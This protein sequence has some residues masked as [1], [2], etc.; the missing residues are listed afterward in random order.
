MRRSE[1]STIIAEL[2]DRA[3]K[4]ESSTAV[5][6]TGPRATIANAVE[7]VASAID[8]TM[9]VSKYLGETEENLGT[10]FEDAEDRDLVLVF[11]DADVLFGKRDVKDGQDSTA[12]LGVLLERIRRRVG[13]TLV[14]TDSRDIPKRQRGL[15]DRV[16]ELDGEG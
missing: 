9:V 10:I 2:T 16:I 14:V 3:S 12:R 15:F 5:L 4:T 11:D 6:L 1:I 7:G 13:V 8:P